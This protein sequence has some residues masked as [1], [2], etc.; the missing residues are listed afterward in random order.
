M[1]QML[2]ITWPVRC[3]D[4][5]FCLCLTS[6]GERGLSV[7]NYST[8]TN[9]PFA[10]VKR[11]GEG[12]EATNQQAYIAILS[13]GTWF[14][15]WTQASLESSADQRQV[16]SRS[17]DGGR[18]W[19]EPVVIEESVGDGAPGYGWFASW[20]MPFAVPHTDR[21]YVFYW[22]QRFARHRYPE[23]QSGVMCF[24]FSDDEGRTWS[25]RFTIETPRHEISAIPERPHGWN[26]GPPVLLPNGKVAFTYNKNSVSSSNPNWR[27]WAGE[28]H[29]MVCSNLLTETE[30]TCL[31]FE[32]YPRG[33]RGLR[34][35]TARYGNF[36]A[37]QHFIQK[38]NVSPETQFD[39]HELTLAPLPD[40]RLL[41]IARTK[42]GCL[43]HAVSEDWGETWSN[44]EPLRY[45]PG[46]PAIAQPVCSPPVT[47]LADGRL[48]LLFH[49]NDGSA[50]G[51]QDVW[52]FHRNRTPLWVAVGRQGHVRKN[53]GLF[54]KAP[55]VLLTNDAQPEGADRRTEISY[56]QFFTFAG[57]YFVLYNDK[58]RDIKI[59][60][61]DPALVDAAGLPT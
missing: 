10:V 36:P 46:G 43:F 1:I 8:N 47:R 50:H 37:F 55:R 38:Y 2:L 19:S 54:F 53:A 26:F 13:S 48:V 35:D 23:H 18:T 61:V 42:M 14:V 28:G 6:F 20:G 16:C 17:D 30:P 27:V 40:G 59:N 29:I 15:C 44:P 34:V 51:G 21:I 58:K 49:N 45:S 60:E 7:S 9:A 39:F 57:R 24:R 12:I 33:P 56:P 22:W 32:S 3:Q 41:T 4:S 5:S 31:R 52:D 11:R 25:D